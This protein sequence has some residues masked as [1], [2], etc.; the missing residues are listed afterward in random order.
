LVDSGTSANCK[1]SSTECEAEAHRKRLGQRIRF[2]LDLVTLLDA[3]ELS[4]LRCSGTNCALARLREVM[5]RHPNSFTLTAQVPSAIRRLFLHRGRSDARHL[6]AAGLSLKEIGDHL[7]HRKEDATRIYA[8]VD[9]AGLRE[10][11]NFDLRGLS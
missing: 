3:P 9:L 11:A 2:G 4:F 7:G 10:V 6:V 1:P 8:K 5:G